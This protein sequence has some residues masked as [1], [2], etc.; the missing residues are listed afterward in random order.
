VP[1]W[2]H[3][4]AE[5]ADL[6][7]EIARFHGYEH[8]PVTVPSVR[9]IEVRFAPEHDALAALRRL[10]VGYGLTEVCNWT[11]SSDDAVRNCGLEDAYLDM[12]RL[13]NPLSERQAA[14]RSSLAPGI[15]NNVAFNIRHG[16]NDLA[17]FE[18]GPVYRPRADRELPD[19]TPGL[20][21]ALSGAAEDRYW[22]R[23]PRA[24]DFH[25]LKGLAERVI[26]HFGAGFEFTVSES[27]L[28]Q[29]GQ[30]ANIAAD[31]EVIGRC[32]RIHPHVLRSLD[33]PQDVYLLELNL[34]PLLR[35][36]QRYSQFQSIPAFPPSLRDMA[37]VVDAEVPAGAICEAARRAGGKLLQRVEIFDI[38][39]GKQVPAGKKS[40]ALGFVFQSPDRTLI[41]ADT[42][43][44]CDKILRALK[45]AYQAELR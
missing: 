4:V 8:I 42:E 9:P 32:G 45:H 11:F 39:E 10:L 37:V 25:D 14:M 31:G 17:L 21:I 7:E 18:I 26:E 1:T 41:D 27:A 29:A 12:V 28:F 34:D 23:A 3:D 6:I 30:G 38:Y 35:L 5:E 2:R 33:I 24:V 44:A 36:P 19:E 43:K 22:S 13:E 16:S 15:L 40:V 20:A